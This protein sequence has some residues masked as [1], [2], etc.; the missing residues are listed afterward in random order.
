MS[1]VKMFNPTKTIPMIEHT[2]PA[3][4][5]LPTYPAFFALLD[6]TIPRKLK[7]REIVNMTTP[8]II[9]VIDDSGINKKAIIGIMKRIAIDRIPH[10]KDA[11]ALR[12]LGSAN[13]NSTFSIHSNKSINPMEGG[14]TNTHKRGTPKRESG[15][16]GS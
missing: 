14:N 7:N 12:L 11:F 6:K 10:N 15:L 1:P 4:G 5:I 8:I 16:S 3:V 9:P 2:K 13:G